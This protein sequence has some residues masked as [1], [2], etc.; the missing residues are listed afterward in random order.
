MKELERLDK[1]DFNR[2]YRMCKIPLNHFKITD[3]EI[4]EFNNILKAL[5]DNDFSKVSKEAFTCFYELS[6]CHPCYSYTFDNSG[7]QLLICDDDYVYK[8]QLRNMPKYD[9]KE[10]SGGVAF[11]KFKK[12]L[13]ENGINLDDYAITNG[14]EVKKEI[15]LPM[16][17]LGDSA[18]LD[19][20]YIHCHHID[21]HNSYPGGL[22]IT[23]PEFRPVIEM[24]Y[25]KRK[26][27]PVYKAILNLSIGYM[28]SKYCG[29]KF[30]H[31][32][33]DA[34]N[35][36]NERVRKVS[37]DLEDNDRMILLYN[38]DGIWYSGDVWHG[39]LEGKNVGEWENDH[40]ECELRIKSKGCYEF[41]ENGVYTPVVRGITKYDE[42]KDRHE[43]KWGDIYKSEI[44]MFGCS[45]DGI[46][47]LEGD[48][49][50]GN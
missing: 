43:W 13:K 19:V 31:L 45:E 29:Y 16:I 3:S 33:R 24:L 25:Q 23:H 18:L 36:N 27:E 2:N 37:K 12:I 50:N 7:A 15:E 39:E 47:K 34:I 41:I 1:I 4:N 6:A 5:R 8:M 40:I 17:E 28:Q 32:S 11:K 20:T 21:F 22:C 14:L 46:I 44:I 10:I 26:T 38:T 30:A 48:D 42:I 49:Y 9:S 35:N